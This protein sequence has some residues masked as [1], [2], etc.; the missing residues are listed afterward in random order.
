MLRPVRK[1]WATIIQIKATKK[2]ND[3]NK[4]VLLVML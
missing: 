4:D 1:T 3:E 2:I